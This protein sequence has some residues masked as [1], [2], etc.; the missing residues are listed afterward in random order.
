[1]PGIGVLRIPA[2]DADSI[3]NPK[4]YL[5]RNII[6]YSKQYLH[7][8]YRRGTKGPKSFDC[9]G[10]THYVFKHFGY[11]LN[12]GCTTQIHQGTKVKK[13][14]LETGDLIF[15]KGRNAK[16]NRV[17]HV[18]IVVSNEE[19]RISFIHAC[20]RGVIIEELDH[21]PYYKPRYVTGVRVI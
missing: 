11:D 4:T 18:G 17:G 7:H 8:P 6:E 5:V 3:S 19:G 12:A 2:P 9:S 10:F 1:M 15:F 13:E 20:S 16:S 14:E 21:S